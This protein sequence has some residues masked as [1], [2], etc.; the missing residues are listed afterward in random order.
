MNDGEKSPDRL[1][2][3]SSALCMCVRACVRESVRAYVRERASVRERACV[4]AR[5]SV[6]PCERERACVRMSKR[7]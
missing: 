7:V 3:A 5:E 1:V 2:Y 4:R 6:R